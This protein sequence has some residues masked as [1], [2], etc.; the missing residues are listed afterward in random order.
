[1]IKAKVTEK[2]IKEGYRNIITISYC[3]AQNLLR[4]KNPIFYTSGVYGWKSD[5]YIINNNTIISTGYAP[6]SGI[7]D[8]EL[9]EEYEQKANKINHNYNIEYEKQQELVNKLLDEFIKKIL[10]GNK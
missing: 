10:E 4:Y 7:R 2:Q 8:Y 9:V 1:M 6:I 5:I 3:E